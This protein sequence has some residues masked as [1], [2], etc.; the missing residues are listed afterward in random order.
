MVSHPLSPVSRLEQLLLLCH[1]KKVKD[2][3]L[4]TFARKVRAMDRIRDS[5][6][7]L[8]LGSSHAQ[9][10]W[11]AKEG[12]FNLGMAY[13]DLYYSSQLYR[14]YIDAPSLKTVVI[15]YSVFSQGHQ[16]IRTRDARACV[17][18]Q[19]V[20]GIDWENADVAATLHLKRLCFAYRRKT[21]GF[22]ASHEYEPGDCGNERG[23]VPLVTGTARERALAHFKNSHRDVEMTR[24]LAHL[25]SDAGKHGHAVCIVIPPASVAYRRELPGGSQIFGD[26]KGTVSKW[27]NVML[28]DHYEDPRFVQSDFIDWDHLSPAGAAKLTGLVRKEIEDGSKIQ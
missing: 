6:E 10:G 11:I 20:A 25:V 21:A 12:E 18:F 13:Q 2:N 3:I 9:M 23:Y 24:F 8:V 16:T 28:F 19:T 5:V 17:T 14:R 27:E 4:K 7:T 1:I 26:F 22:L 15:F